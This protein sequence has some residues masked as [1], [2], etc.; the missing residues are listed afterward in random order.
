MPKFACWLVV[1]ILA[2]GNSCIELAAQ[3][4]E[5]P[6][7]PIRLVAPF[8]AGGGGDISAR[9]LA[10]A[11][12]N[13]LSQPVIVE[14]RPGA[15]GVAAAQAVLNAAPDGYTA[16]VLGNINA[17]AHSMLKTIPYDI[18]R[19]FIPVS[20]V[21]TTDVVAFANKSSPFGNV[22]DVVGAAKTKPG[23]INIGVG[24]IGTTQ[25]LTA[26]LFKL[27]TDIDAVIVPFR[28]SADLVT[29]VRRG[30]VDVGFELLAPVVGLLATNDLKALA[31]GA[32]KRSPLLPSTPT[33]AESGIGVN[34]TSWAMIAAPVGTPDSVVARLNGVISAAL[35]KPDVQKKFEALSFEAGGGSPANARAFLLAEIAKWQS[36]IEARQ[37]S[38]K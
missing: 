23:A 12:G 2:Y 26:E 27:T 31:V 9:I 36:V 19:D 22:R 3:P 32:P 18:A 5:Y 11:M 1:F 7:G 10:D 29:A 4:K 35:A 13:I 28:T 17:I 20:I 37:L 15:G 30:D 24:L 21:I 34:V 16:L 8:A 25:H 6:A 33:F 14:N 38:S